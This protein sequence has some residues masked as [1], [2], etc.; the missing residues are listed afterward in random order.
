[1]II[2]PYKIIADLMM[3]NGEYSILIVC[4]TPRQAD[5]AYSWFVQNIDGDKTMHLSRRNGYIGN[6]KNILH[7][8]IN[9]ENIGRGR[10]PHLIIADFTVNLSEMSAISGYGFPPLIR[11]MDWEVAGLKQDL[12]LNKE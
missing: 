6:K 4:R 5:I 9:S 1:M 10:Q 11:D 3:S 12:E 7:I 2:S 8:K